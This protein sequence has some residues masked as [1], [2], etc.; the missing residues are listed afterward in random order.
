M[1][2]NI[3]ELSYPI[4]VV[5]LFETEIISSSTGGNLFKWAPKSFW[6][7]PQ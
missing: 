6:H 7:E 1:D 2:L 5:L 4:G 3:F